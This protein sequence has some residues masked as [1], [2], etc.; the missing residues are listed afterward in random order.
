MTQERLSDAIAET[1]GKRVQL[2]PTS[3]R[4]KRLSDSRRGHRKLRQKSVVWLI[5]LTGKSLLPQRDSEMESQRLETD[6]TRD[7]QTVRRSHRKLR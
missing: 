1:E 2:C 5:S 7:S 3:S 4:D 6:L